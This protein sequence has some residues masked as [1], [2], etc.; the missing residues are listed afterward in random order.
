M[1]T[2]RLLEAALLCTLLLA[3]QPGKP[4]WDPQPSGVTDDLQAVSFVSNKTGWAAGDHNIVIKTAD[5]GAT[6]KL[7]TERQGL[8]K[9]TSVDFVD[10]S[11]GWVQSMSVLLHS[12]DGGDS[13]QPATLLPGGGFAAAGILATVRDQVNVHGTERTVYRT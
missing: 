12:T 10:E 11:E 5:G 1:L 2:V 3:A 8:N 13:W 6:W 7:L 9:F 4:R